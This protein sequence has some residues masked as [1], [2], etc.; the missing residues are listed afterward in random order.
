MP[1][2]RLRS[3][4]G[5]AGLISNSLDDHTVTLGATQNFDISGRRALIKDSKVEMLISVT[6]PSFRSGFL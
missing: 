5:D 2:T 3:L 6:T 4:S 1:I